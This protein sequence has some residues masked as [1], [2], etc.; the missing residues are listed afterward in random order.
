M[1]DL[2]VCIDALLADWRQQEEQGFN[3]L[4]R[5]SFYHWYSLFTSH[6]LTPK[7]GHVNYLKK[8]TFHPIYSQLSIT[9]KNLFDI[10]YQWISFWRILILQ[11]FYTP[12]QDHNANRA[13]HPTKILGTSQV[14]TGKKPEEDKRK[15]NFN[16]LLILA[17][18]SL[19]LCL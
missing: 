8:P 12:H 18:A 4:S 13:A 11:W 15:V 6:L 1:R 10:Y 16:R 9:Y 14:E 5:D 7:Y 3:A 17:H 19:I 2:T